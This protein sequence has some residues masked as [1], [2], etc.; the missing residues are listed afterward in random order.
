MQ[1]KSDFRYATH[2]RLGN[3]DA[4]Q[5][6]NNYAQNITISGELIAKSQLQLEA[7]ENMANEKKERTMVFADGTAK[8]VLI[9]SIKKSREG[10]LKDG[11]FLRQAYT[12]EMVVVL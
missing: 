7:F 8:S 11:A 3:F 9:I 5:S 12:I 4:Y 2:K 10:F 1:M 6:I